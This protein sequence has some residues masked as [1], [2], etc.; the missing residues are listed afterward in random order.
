MTVLIHPGFHKTGTTW[1][2]TELFQERRIFNS[3]FSHAEIDNL[4]VR[5]HDFNFDA[6]RATKAVT[7]K[8]SRPEEGLVDVITSE[9]LSGNPFTGSR[10]SRANALRLSRSVGKAK[11]LFTVRAQRPML[12]SLYMQYVQRGGRRS[13][14]EFVGRE[15]EPGYFGF[16]IDLLKF[17]RLVEFY[18]E[19]F[20]DDNVLVL[21]QEL[22]ARDR[23][24]YFTKLY[25]FLKGTAPVASLSI[26]QRREV[27]ASPPTSGLPLLRM[28]NL[29]RRTPVNPEAVIAFDPIGRLMHR[30]AYHFRVREKR[31]RVRLDNAAHRLIDDRFR[32]SNARLQRFSPVDLAQLGYDT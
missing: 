23:R 11:V 5:P 12:R 16:D 17:N 10:D 3:M 21:P 25:E 1:L 30:A 19:L 32:A 8:Q 4:F 18:G 31:A 24:T 6:E 7:D 13:I 27:G 2:Q 28:A 15:C 22:L 29:I 20:G 26:S 14:D 9:I